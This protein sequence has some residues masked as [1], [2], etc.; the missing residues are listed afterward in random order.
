[1]EID[2]EIAQI[3]AFD[4]SRRCYSMDFYDVIKKRQSVRLFKTDSI[5]QES[6]N[7][8]LEAF[9]A[10][11]SWANTQPWELVLVTDPDI[12]KE[13]QNTVPERNPSHAGIGDA[14]LLVCAIGITGISGFYQGT[15]STD[16]GDWV[17]FDLGIALEHLVLAGVAEGLGSVHVGVFN[18]Q[19]AAKILELP[20]DRTVM[21]LIPMGYPAYNPR[22]VPRKPIETFVFKNKYGQ[23]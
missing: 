16:R 13:L 20:K 1:M 21:E 17:M 8:M 15:Q 23:N 19:K 10:A 11:P 7:R 9:Q 5:P 12:R 2:R 14:P 22:I 3:N 4:P 6:L 18:H